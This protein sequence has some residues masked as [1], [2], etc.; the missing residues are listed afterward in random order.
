MFKFKLKMIVILVMLPFMS[1]EA[2][3][4]SICAGF[5][6]FYTRECRQ[7]IE[8]DIVSCRSSL[9]QVPGNSTP[10]DIFNNLQQQYDS[11]QADG[12]EH[13]VKVL[14]E[15]IITSIKP[16]ITGE[17]LEQKKKDLFALSG[18][19]NTLGS[20]NEE[21][22]SS[23]VDVNG[24]CLSAFIAIHIGLI[25][26]NTFT[27]SVIQGIMVMLAFLNKAG[28][29][30]T[31]SSS[32]NSMRQ[33]FY[34]AVSTIPNSDEILDLATG[35]PEFT[36]KWG[37]NRAMKIHFQIFTY[38]FKQIFS[39]PLPT[40]AKFQKYGLNKGFQALW[41]KTPVPGTLTLISA[42]KSN[43]A[44]SGDLF[45]DRSDMAYVAKMSFVQKGFQEANKYYGNILSLVHLLPALAQHEELW[46]FKVDSLFEMYTLESNV[47][48]KRPE[49]YNSLCESQDTEQKA[50]RATRLLLTKLEEFVKFGFYFHRDHLITN[51][52]LN[53]SVYT[54][55]KD[56]FLEHSDKFGEGKLLTTIN[57]ILDQIATS[58]EVKF[59]EKFKDL[60][61]RVSDI[62]V[63]VSDSPLYENLKNHKDEGFFEYVFN[64]ICPS[65][66][67][68]I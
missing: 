11:L 41:F 8:E 39:A 63:R 35:G 18:A 17:T 60:A 56:Y 67:V 38:V 12:R 27:N 44:E 22:A 14:L 16:K 61:G 66:R 19:M 15:Y 31:V 4:D 3:F 59:L 49:D 68:L 46:T 2:F 47:E 43:F 42:I 5:N 33:N 25:A 20:T 26:D 23:Q 52:R 21:S 45:N 65:E 50:R 34:K 6:R 10:T 30:V 54:S 28:D 55:F 62:T 9:Q 36:E 58:R 29:L 53:Y 37:L 51:E 1:L 40:D 64:E 48:G 13:S 57:T 24:I 7:K 32:Y